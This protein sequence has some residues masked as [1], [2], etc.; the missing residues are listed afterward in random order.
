M[1]TSEQI[2][3][4]IVHNA[5][6]ATKQI[7]PQDVASVAYKLG[8]EKGDHRL[9]ALFCD[10][11]LKAFKNFNDDFDHNGER[12]VLRRLASL[13]LKTI[14]DVGANEGDWTAM[15]SAEVPNADIHAFEIIDETFALL[16]KKCAS[17]EKIRCNNF[18]LFSRSGEINMHVYDASNTFSSHVNY[19]NG[20]HHEKV[21]PVRTG[22]DYVREKNVEKIDFLKIDVEG[23]EFDVLKGFSEA[24][25]RKSI[26]VV[27]FEYGKVS[28]M[29]H[30]LLYDFYGFF[31]SKGY[32]VGKIYPE[33]VDFRAYTLDD[34]DFLGPNYL[35]CLRQR[36]D[37]I[38]L[39]GK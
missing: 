25:D 33:Y 23:A 12:M 4:S 29:T 28:I 21:C 11:F 9:M 38:K 1:F 34:E 27:Q 13:D 22:D 14:V 32:A 17:N 5:L 31:E 35:A 26:D 37:I 36:T 6:G 18:G 24:I 10:Y 7:T 19:P 20:A 3:A 15:A 8:R 16:S 30:I 39:L 2:A